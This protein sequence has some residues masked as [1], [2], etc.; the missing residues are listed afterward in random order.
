MNIVKVLLTPVAVAMVAAVAVPVAVAPAVVMTIRQIMALI[1]VMNMPVGTK[2]HASVHGH[3]V[4]RVILAITAVAA[5][6]QNAPA[7]IQTVAVMVQTYIVAINRAPRHARD[8]HVR[9]MQPV[10]MAVHQP[11]AHN[12]MVVHAVHRLQ[13]VQSA[14]LVNQDIIKAAAVV[15]HAV[16]INIIAPVEPARVYHLGI[17]P[18]AAHP[19]PERVKQPVAVINIIAVVVCAIVYQQGIIQRVEVPPPE[20]VKSNAPVQHIASVGLN[21]IV[22]NQLKM[23]ISLLVIGIGH[24]MV[25]TIN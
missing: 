21:M 18:Q 15:R 23:Q 6:V 4:I 25:F 5:V 3:T 14:Y 10:P 7:V 20:Q 24:Q 11:V 13:H 8:K 2:V 19:P 22:Q 16:V 17:I 9:L 1:P 12:I